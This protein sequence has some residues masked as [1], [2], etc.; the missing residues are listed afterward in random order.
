[1]KFHIPNRIAVV[2]S[3]MLLV[4]VAAM[5]QVPPRPDPP[6]LVNDLAG[7]LTPQQEQWLED[8]LARFDR[9][10]SNQVAVVILADLGDMDPA[11]MAYEIGE[12]W[13]VGTSE[14]NNG[15]VILVKPKT[16]SSRG[17]AFIATGY[18]LEGALPDATCK[19]IVE[20]E[21]IPHFKQNDYF[22]GIVAAVGVVCPIA[23]GEY[24]KER[25]EEDGGGAVAGLLAL[26]AA[27]FMFFIIVVVMRKSGG[28]NGNRGDGFGG[29]GTFGPGGIFLGGLPFGHIGGSGR[30]VGFDSGGFGGGG[31]G[32]FGGGS[33]GGGGAG[34][35]W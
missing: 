26:G 24:S 4:A 7:I 23:A 8:S 33:F 2:L 1:M 22:G 3:A 11:E 34:G 10:T 19:M 27:L 20:R 15:V 6:R 14:D 29:T 32:G 9:R 25:Y 16:T 12:Q 17:Q 13:Q 31:F 28:N 18:G 21:M 35:S 30:S 5:A